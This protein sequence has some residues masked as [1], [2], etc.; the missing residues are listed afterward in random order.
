M[1]TIVFVAAG[2][3]TPAGDNVQM[4]HWCIITAV[5]RTKQFVSS[6]LLIAMIDHYLIAS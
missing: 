6:L 2:V 3:N 5:L 1:D 4:H